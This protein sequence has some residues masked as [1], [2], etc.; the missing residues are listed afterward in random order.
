MKNCFSAGGTVSN[1]WE[2]AW[3]NVVQKQGTHSELYFVFHSIL[4]PCPGVKC[5]HGGI[6]FQTPY[7]FMAAKLLL[8]PKETSTKTFKCN[9]IFLGV[10]MFTVT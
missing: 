5:K 3:K 10:S 9:L 2:T 1:K 4:I 8:Q 6:T 7:L